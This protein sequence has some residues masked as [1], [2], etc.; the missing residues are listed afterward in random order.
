MPIMVNYSSICVDIVAD[1]SNVLGQNFRLLLNFHL[2]MDITVVSILFLSSL[3]FVK[4][5]FMLGDPLKHCTSSQILI[6][7]ELQYFF[8]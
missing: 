7:I 8:S 6:I 4:S 3:N 5:Y 2:Y 1:M